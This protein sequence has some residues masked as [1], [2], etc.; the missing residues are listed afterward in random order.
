MNKRLVLV[1][2][3]QQRDNNIT[4]TYKMAEIKE[5]FATMEETQN[6]IRISFNIY[7]LSLPSLDAQNTG[8]L[9]A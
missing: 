5:N 3:P 1:P 9:L 4:P 8:G 2:H 7:I 6:F